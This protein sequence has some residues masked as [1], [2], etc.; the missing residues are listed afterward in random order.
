MDRT[1]VH[2]LAV[3]L[4]WASG[5]T[6]P[7]MTAGAQITTE[8]VMLTGSPGG[9]GDAQFDFSEW[10]ALH[11]DGRLAFRG[12]LNQD[13]A[14]VTPNN[15]SAIWAT[16]NG[17][18]VIAAR[19]GAEAPGVG[20]GLFASFPVGLS[21]QTPIN[22]QGRIA[23]RA[24]LK[25][26]PP[27]TGENDAGIWAGMPLALQLVART[28]DPAPFVAGAFYAGFDR[29][30]MNDRDEIALR[31]QL[32][33]NEGV[34]DSSNSACVVAFRQSEAEL[35]AR[36]GDPAPGAGGALFSQFDEFPMLNDNGDVVFLATLL[37]DVAG[38]DDSSDTGIWMSR[39][40]VTTLLAREGDEAPL[41]GGARFDDLM[42]A[43]VTTSAS[44]NVAVLAEL[45]DGPGGVDF[46]SD[47]AIW[48]WSDD[49]ASILA[50]E[51]SP[52]P[53]FGT[54]VFAV[55]YAYP[56]MNASGDIAFIASLA[57]NG[58][59]IDSS[60]NNGVWVSSDEGVQVI[61]REGDPTPGIGGSVFVGFE[62]IR[63]NDRRDVAV[64]GLT[65]VGI[66]FDFKGIWYYTDSTGRL[67]HILHEFGTYDTDD[68]PILEHT[69][70]ISILEF[71]RPWRAGDGR[72]EGVNNDGQVACWV[73]FNGRTDA[74]AVVLATVGASACSLADLAE[75]HGALDFSDV[76]AFLDAF[77]NSDVTADLAEPYYAFDFSD[78]FAFLQLFGAGCP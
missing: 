40:G 21:N 78:V 25:H 55:L 63:I 18:C 37:H 42:F 24:E 73:L 69:L 41:S 51:G 71:E 20:G 72:G 59:D 38:V 19:E 26:V 64:M 46:S 22:A 77:V 13:G 5:M 23:F 32:T 36:Q 68:H 49:G 62:Y 28:G 43:D 9:V 14:E 52:A 50:R 75:P 30:G 4:A 10:P 76:F 47:R 35:I 60:N 11:S 6:A 8:T 15:D 70:Q 34:I 33:D 67:D 54:T 65:E 31:A 44:G 2:G 45:K 57:T 7:V 66:S 39:D 17:T 12:K 16:Q 74:S 3:M 56:S 1:P 61:V 48:V 53:G 58:D 27:V 29:P